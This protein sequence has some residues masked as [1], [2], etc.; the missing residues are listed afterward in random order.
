MKQSRLL[1]GSL[2]LILLG[3]M[4]GFPSPAHAL[5]MYSTISLYNYSL[6]DTVTTNVGT[7]L[8]VPYFWI[9]QRS[10]TMCTT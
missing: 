7:N 10:Q 2:S 9:L 1:S 4:W 5:P 6:V 3:C 8:Q